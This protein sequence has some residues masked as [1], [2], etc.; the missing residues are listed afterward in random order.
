MNKNM[1]I[2]ER[3]KM[4]KLQIQ[5]EKSYLSDL[6]ID[7]ASIFQIVKKFI[8]QWD[9]FG[10]LAIECPPDEYESEI[11][12]I[13]IYITKHLNDLDVHELEKHIRSTFEDTFEEDVV[14]DQRSV[15]VTNAIFTSLKEGKFIFPC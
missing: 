3:L 7:T 9:P 5:E 8:D 15:D 4:A 12:R 13:T 11:R 1:S 6:P 10:L 14:Q 2:E